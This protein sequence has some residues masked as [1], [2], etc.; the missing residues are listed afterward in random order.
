MYVIE[1]IYRVHG[2]L[3]QAYWQTLYMHDVLKY[4]VG[5]IKDPAW[6]D[7]LSL[8]AVSGQCMYFVL[9]DGNPVLEFATDGMLGGSLRL[10]GSVHPD[11]AF[12]EMIQVHRWTAEEVLTW[13]GVSSLMG[14]VASL[15]RRA[16]LLAYKAGWRKVGVINAGCWYAGEHVE[17]TVVSYG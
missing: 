12:K 5:N 2:D 6:S 3:V 7:V 15:N 8:I 9:K 11:L 17:G 16:L 14:S 1:P 4:R 13:K 10:H